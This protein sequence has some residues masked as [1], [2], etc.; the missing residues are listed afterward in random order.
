MTLRCSSHNADQLSLEYG[1]LVQL[2]QQGNAT[3]IYKSTGCMPS[4]DRYEYGFHPK[5]EYREPA[6]ADSLFLQFVFTSG[7]H[8]MREK[9]RSVQISSIT[10]RLIHFLC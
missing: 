5:I 10:D 9:A 1:K 3:Q 2:L 8:E 6:E 4:C 7:R